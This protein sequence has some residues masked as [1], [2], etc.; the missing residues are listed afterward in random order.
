MRV[1]FM[2]TP[3][4]A[5]PALERIV[6]RGHEII[7]V[8]T[9]APK[10][11][12]R[13]G[14]MEVPS[15]VHAT[16]A[17]LGL[18]VLTPSTLRKPEAAD[19]FRSHQ[20]DVAVVAAYGLLLPLPILEAPLYGCVNLHASLLPRWRGAAP[21]HRAVMAGDARTG[22]TLMRMEEGLDTGPAGPNEQIDIGENDTTGD[23]HDRLAGLAAALVARAL[24]ELERGELV[25][26][27]QPDEGVTY[28]RKI[29]KSECPIDWSRPA[30]AVHDH[31]RGLSP[32]PGAYFEVDLGRGPERIKVLES[33]LAEGE[34]PPGVALDDR[35]TIACGSGAVRLSS[36][37]RAG[38]QRMSAEVF[39]RGASLPAGAIVR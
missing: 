35:L 6:E 10:P 12:G 28:A 2:G 14:L 7:A 13:R 31:I 36:L 16:A 5:A 25:F 39:L 17:R 32:F 30:K 15:A 33:R 24:P 37:Q 22:V 38:K 1:V 9:R 20:A 26:T 4:F 23:V 19:I 34:G 29:D 8:Y 11:A 18:P 21:I 27:P 3:D